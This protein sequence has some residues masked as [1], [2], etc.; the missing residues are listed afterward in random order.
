MAVPGRP[1]G[2][3]PRAKKGAAVIQ[4]IQ[5]VTAVKPQL[6]HD[7]RRADGT[8]ALTGGECLAGEEPRCGCS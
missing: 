4:P 5:R 3:W 6:G 8:T 1:D 7:G 2:L